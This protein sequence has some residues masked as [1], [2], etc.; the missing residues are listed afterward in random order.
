MAVFSMVHANFRPANFYAHAGG[1]RGRQT[2]PRGKDFQNDR[3]A[4][5]HE[6][7]APPGANAERFQTPRFLVVRFK[8][9]DNAAN[10]R[11]KLVQADTF[12]GNKAG[13]CHKFSNQISIR[14]K[15]ALPFVC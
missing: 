14:R 3:V 4:A 8:I 6:F 2:E 7:H 12:V 15:I 1:E 5:A 11:R 9:A 10:A 13:R